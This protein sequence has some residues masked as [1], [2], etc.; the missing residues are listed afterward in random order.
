LGTKSPPERH[1]DSEVVMRVLVLALES[2]ECYA[3]W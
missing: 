3:G 2:W 1:L